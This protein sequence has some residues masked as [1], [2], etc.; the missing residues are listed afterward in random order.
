MDYFFFYVGLSF[1]FTHELDAVKMKEWKMVP[2][3]SILKEQTGYYIFIALHIPLFILLFW[4]LYGSYPNEV[5][6]TLIFWLD[7]S[8]IV[9]FFLHLGFLRHKN[10]LF[11]SAFSWILITGTG[12]CAI[13]DLT[14]NLT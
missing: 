2:I 6:T 8:F 11:K 3:L 10:N 1:I 13:L 12:I 5:N 14:I 4:G 9:H 7:I